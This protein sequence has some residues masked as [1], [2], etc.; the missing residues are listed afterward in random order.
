MLQELSVAQ[1]TNF[2]SLLHTSMPQLQAT[3][4]A[5]SAN[6]YCSAVGWDMDSYFLAFQRASGCLLTSNSF[7]FSR[8]VILVCWGLK[9]VQIIS[10]LLGTGEVMWSTAAVFPRVLAEPYLYPPSM[11]INQELPGAG[12]H[13][14]IHS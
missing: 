13:E 6:L 12:R 1:R 14:N 7:A 4:L 3:I 8:A 5:Q 11:K 9:S 10:H 2:L